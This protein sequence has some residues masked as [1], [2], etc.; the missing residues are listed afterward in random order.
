MD[1]STANINPETGIRYGVTSSHALAELF[2]HISINGTDLYYEDWLKEIQASLSALDF[3][4]SPELE[5]AEFKKGI[6]GFCEE[7]Y[8]LDRYQEMLLKVWS[9][10]PSGSPL[11][12]QL[13]DAICDEVGECYEQDSS[14]Y[15]YTGSGN[16]AGFE[17]LYSTS[18]GNIITVIE[19]PRIVYAERLC[20]PC[21]PNAA[22]LDSGITNPE[23]GYECYAVPEYWLEEES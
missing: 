11:S 9:D 18:N 5:Y 1:R 21:Y 14:L 13:Y 6:Q 2:S 20:S 4:D 3:D 22:D 17:C 19:S 8:L 7:Y 16:D 10:R 15:H 23:D 12:S